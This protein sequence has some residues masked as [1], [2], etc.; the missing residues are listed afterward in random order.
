[1][2][3][4]DHLMQLQFLAAAFGDAV[5]AAYRT[6]CSARIPR[7]S[8]EDEFHWHPGAAPFLDQPRERGHAILEP[9]D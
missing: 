5:E 3:S 4:H 9:A 1:M 2:P 7:S 6:L 8:D